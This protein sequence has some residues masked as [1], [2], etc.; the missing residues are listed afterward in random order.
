MSKCVPLPG[1]ACVGVHRCCS[2]GKPHAIKEENYLLFGVVEEKALKTPSC[3]ISFD[4]WTIRRHVLYDRDTNAA[5]VLQSAWR[6]Y[7][8]RRRRLTERAQRAVS[9]ASIVVKLAHAPAAA[10]A[11]AEAAAET[12]PASSEPATPSLLHMSPRD[13]GIDL[14]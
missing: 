13:A 11:A 3:T 14:G 4:F 5:V 8:E 6:A 12:P 1:D 7:G 9:R 2:A 10:A